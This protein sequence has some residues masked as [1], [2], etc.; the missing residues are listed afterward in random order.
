M[1]IYLK[2]SEG[3]DRMIPRLLMMHNEL[4]LTNDCVTSLD[5]L[6]ERKIYTGYIGYE[7]QNTYS[8]VQCL[9]EWKEFSFVW[10]DLQNSYVTDR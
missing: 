2:S 4:T 3:I 10:L 6:K 5:N 8:T 7:L 1:G 9:S